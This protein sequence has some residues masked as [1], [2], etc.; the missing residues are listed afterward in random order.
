MDFK[1]YIAPDLPNVLYGD[2][3]SIK[4]VVTNLLSNASK[5]TDKGF[6]KYEVNCIRSTDACKLII[7]VED[8][9]RGIKKESVDKL[10]TKFQ[11]VEEDKNTTIEGTGLG[12]AITKQLV[13]LMGG[14][15]IVHTIYGEGS[16][17]TVVINQKIESKT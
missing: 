1:Y 3:A 11:R 12:L 15:I 14:K 4:K 5:Y 16:K 17:F 2:H 10:F 7:T 6:V 8:S 9:G 13:E